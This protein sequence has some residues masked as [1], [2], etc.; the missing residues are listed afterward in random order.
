[1]NAIRMA[2]ANILKLNEAIRRFTLGQI[3]SQ[4]HLAMYSLAHSEGLAS[5]QYKR[6]QRDIDLSSATGGSFRFMTQAQNRAEQAE[7]PWRV[8]GAQI[9]NLAA[10][11]LTHARSYVIEII[12]KLIFLEKIN[13]MLVKVLEYF[14][15]TG[16]KLMFDALMEHIGEIAKERSKPPKAKIP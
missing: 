6:I 14:E 12:N 16:D 15:I 4:S 9:K 1:M 8:L 11:G 3:A 7:Q 10:G 2:S 13:E 5:L